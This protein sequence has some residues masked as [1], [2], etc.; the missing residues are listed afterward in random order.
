MAQ[1]SRAAVAITVVWMLACLSTLAGVAVV[2]G[3]VG[4]MRFFPAAAGQRHP[5]APVAGTL[6]MVALVTGVVNLLLL[7]IS[8]RVRRVPPPRAIVV[9]SVMSGIL[10]VGL[11]LTWSW[12][13]R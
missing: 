4:W 11:L 12:L 1:E 5:L 2:L 10:P 13:I 3:L 7:P 6:L 8:Q 9:L